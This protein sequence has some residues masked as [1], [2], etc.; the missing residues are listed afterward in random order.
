[1]AGMND[2]AQW[3][4]MLGFI[5]SILLIFLALIVNQSALIG[6]TT[7]ESV[8]EFPKSDIQDTRAEIMEYSWNRSI[9]EP[10]LNIT[11]SNL[12]LERKGT[13]VWYNS[14]NDYI[15][16]HYNDGST[17]YNEIVRPP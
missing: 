7:A 12:S 13:I 11:L 6:K 16:I 1:M 10:G 14:T 8:L 5:I 15:M 17:V 3:I 2:D 9:S 4:V